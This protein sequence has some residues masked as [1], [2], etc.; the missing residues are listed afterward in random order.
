[1]DLLSY[2]LA[3]KEDVPILTKLRIDFLKDYWGPNQENESLLE[4]ELTSY[5]KEEIESGEYIAWIAFMG[6]I[7]IATGGMKII[8]KPGSFRIPSGVCAY[9]MNIFTYPTYRRKGIAKT[10][11]NKLIETGKAKG[12]QFF[13]LHATEDGLQLYLNEGFQIH[14]EPTLRKFY[15]D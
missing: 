10:L 2:R 3:Q 8:R 15:L 1:M 12:I 7:P 5:F 13:E 9:I 14:K 11:F 4:T 6:E